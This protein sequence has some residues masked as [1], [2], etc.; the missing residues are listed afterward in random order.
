MI[1]KLKSPVIMIVGIGGGILSNVVRIFSR[2]VLKLLKMKSSHL[3]YKICD[4]VLEIDDD[5][6]T[7]IYGASSFLMYCT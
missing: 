6:I 3:M 1:E 5:R 2:V 4:S 7:S